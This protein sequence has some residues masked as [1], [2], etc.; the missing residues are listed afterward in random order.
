MITD[1]KEVNKK[2][3]SELYNGMQL[4]KCRRCGCMKDTL[5]NMLTSLRSGEIEYYPSN[6]LKI[7]NC[8]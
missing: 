4:A 8:G 3:E 7:F 6:L 2:V 1:K 5:E